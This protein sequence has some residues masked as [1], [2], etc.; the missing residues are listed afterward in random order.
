MTRRPAALPA[1]ASA[2]SWAATIAALVTNA[3]VRL[4]ALALGVALVTALGAIVAAVT[5]RTDHEI[6]DM[7]TRAL[8]EATPRTPPAP[9]GPGGPG[10][11]H[12]IGNMRGS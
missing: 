10:R 9:S 11:L 4:Y 3:P 7:L 1:V 8:R 12:V 6:A 5:V 2:V